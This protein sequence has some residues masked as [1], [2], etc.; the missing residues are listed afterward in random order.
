MASKELL[1]KLQHLSVSCI[2][3]MERVLADVMSSSPPTMHFLLL[4]LCFLYPVAVSGA[5]T[6][7]EMLEH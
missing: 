6:E 7:T 1:P 3:Q 2:V 4:T 5:A